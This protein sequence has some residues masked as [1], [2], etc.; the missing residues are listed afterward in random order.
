MSTTLTPPAATTSWHLVH[1]GLHP[2]PDDLDV[3]PRG[4]VSLIRQ[5]MH[6]DRD[7]RT[8]TRV[9]QLLARFG[10][11]WEPTAEPGHMRFVPPAMS[12]LDGATRYAEAVARRA[13]ERAGIPF[14][15]V[16]GVTVVDHCDPRL[17]G[18]R[19]LLEAAPAAYG[20]TPYLVRPGDG[21]DTVDGLRLRQTG[22][23]Q[24]FSI[25]ADWDL[26]ATA[27]PR[28]LWELSDSYRREPEDTLEL[29]W[30]P[31]RFRLPEG[32]WHA[33]KV[34]EAV[35]LASIAHE[36]VLD[37]ARQL[38]AEV[39][40]LLACTA[41]FAAAHHEFLDK[42]AVGTDGP[43]LLR[44]T[45]PGTLC[46]DGVELDAE[47]KILDAAGQ[48]RELGTFQ[49]DHRITAAFG[50]TAP[51]NPSATIHAVLTGSVERSVSAAFDQAARAEAAGTPAA[52][53]LWACPTWVRLIWAPEHPP[54]PTEVA[55]LSE[56]L[57]S[58][59]VP[60]DIDDRPAPLRHKQALAHTDLVA[61]TIDLTTPANQVVAESAATPDTVRVDQL[62]ATL[63]ARA[64]D[65][66]GLPQ[67]TT[68]RRLTT[69][70]RPPT[71]PA[72]AE[73]REPA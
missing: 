55:T 12:V 49:I 16:G 64:A 1:D 56:T 15:H 24:K 31:R 21:S 25:A 9:A 73:L 43:A 63:R 40:L 47:Y 36:S 39:V 27:A 59:G 68:A 29:G 57:S 6:G 53:P 34:P 13:A 28:C 72:S 62:V 58:N 51:Q 30:R 5:E 70:A 65:I 71:T 11:E 50:L 69:R 41:E 23:L 54:P 3:L 60:T 52:L 66:G 61:Y 42:L 14:D 38:D 33:A 48:A 10:F 44:V 26:P 35:D 46:E 67:R 17:S 32:H 18:Y 2:V 8:P 7:I 20:S 19:T 45:P 22:C 4:L 37:V